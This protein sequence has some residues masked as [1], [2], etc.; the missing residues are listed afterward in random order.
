MIVETGT[1]AEF[2]ASVLSLAIG[3]YCALCFDNV[4]FDQEPPPLYVRYNTPRQ[5][6]ICTRC[7][8]AH[9]KEVLQFYYLL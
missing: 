3:D 5:V 8:N 2:K 7:F 4:S 6:L 1:L 9:T